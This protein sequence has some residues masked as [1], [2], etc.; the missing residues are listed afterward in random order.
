MYKLAVLDI[1]GTL[2]NGNRKLTRYT[3]NI[4]KK[5]KEQNYYVTICTGRNL[6]ITMPIIKKLK[7]DIPFA[8]VDGTVV[9]NPDGSVLYKNNIEY[10]DY[11]EILKIVDEEEVFI[12]VTRDEGY[13]R[14]IKS[15]EVIK[16][17][18]FGTGSMKSSIRNKIERYVL[19]KYVKVFDVKDLNHFTKENYPEVHQV[20]VGGTQK[21]FD[22]ISKKLKD[23]YGDKFDFRDDLWDGCMLINKPEVN[24]L[25]AVKVICE[26]LGVNL[27]EVIA[28][29]DE[30]NDLAM[31]TN[32]GCGIAMGNAKDEIKN[33][34]FD[35][36][37]SNNENGAAYALEHY[38]LNE[39]TTRISKI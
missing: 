29:G 8:C 5:L 38:M 7:I 26:H 19:K 22:N 35:I 3:K 20:G 33:M 24:K 34:T 15:E 18:V 2:I 1:D 11:M 13:Y 27:D 6:G 32:V 23:R 10:D 9:Y 36:T 12:I 14:Y 4:I 17:E 21:H 30:R 37:L 39:N 25:K 28:I 16:Y 31:L